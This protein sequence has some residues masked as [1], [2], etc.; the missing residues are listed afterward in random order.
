MLAV[1]EQAKMKWAYPSVSAWS[2][3]C[4]LNCASVFCVFS[5]F[6]FSLGLGFPFFMLADLLCSVVRF[7]QSGSH[8]YYVFQ[9]YSAIDMLV[10]QLIQLAWHWICHEAAL[11]CREALD[12]DPDCCFTW[13]CVCVRETQT[14][15]GTSTSIHYFSFRGFWLTHCF[16]EMKLNS[17]YSEAVDNGHM[18]NFF[19]EVCLINVQIISFNSF[20]SY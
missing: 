10:P 16:P 13:V 1:Q 9:L 6:L 20:K 3:C 19:S 7:K 4:H 11:S 18:T 8:Q 2:S 5:C 14:M 17:R 15:P 12:P